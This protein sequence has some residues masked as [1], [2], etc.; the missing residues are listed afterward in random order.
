VTIAIDHSRSPLRQWQR[1]A[2]RSIGATFGWTRELLDSSDE[3]S[4]SDWENDAIP[5]N[6]SVPNTDAVVADFS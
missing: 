3:L 2:M 4:V 6:L 5:K 1:E